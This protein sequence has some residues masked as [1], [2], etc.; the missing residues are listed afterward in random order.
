METLPYDI[1]SV[2]LKCYASRCY[3]ITGK[4]YN[5]AREHD[6]M[7]PF[8]KSYDTSEKESSMLVGNTRP[9]VS[10]IKDF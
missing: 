9:S 6:N 1:F 2:S 5:N 10:D 7:I 4:V 3:R 8:L